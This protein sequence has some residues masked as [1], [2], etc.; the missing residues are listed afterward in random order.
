MAR[1]G[2]L[3]Y[4]DASFIKERRNLAICGRHFVHKFSD[5]SACGTPMDGVSIAESPGYLFVQFVR[6]RNKEFFIIE[7]SEIEKD[8]D[9][10]SKFLDEEKAKKL[11]WRIGQL[12]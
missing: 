3:Y 11:T 7:I 5:I 2:K 4:N 12:R 9:S 8:I 6:P 10:G 1:D